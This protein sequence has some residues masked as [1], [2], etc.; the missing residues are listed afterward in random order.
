MQTITK[1]TILQTLAQH[2]SEI[3]GFGVK[4]IG[5]FGSFVR[6][7]ERA[8]SDIDLYVEFEPAM[9]TFDNFMGLCFLLDELFEGRKVE[10]VTENGLS[11][12]I[13]PKILKEVE[14]VAIAS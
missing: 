7:E 13:G 8:E 11:Q 2:R 6:R 10:V 5:L 9:E 1:S 3:R 14:Y 4:Q 12:Y